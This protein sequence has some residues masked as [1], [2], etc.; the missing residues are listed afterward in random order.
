MTEI[1][2]PKR[3][4]R[5]DGLVSSVLG[6]SLSSTPGGIAISCS[7]SLITVGSLIR[8]GLVDVIIEDCHEMNTG[9]GMFR[10]SSEGVSSCDNLTMVAASLYKSLSLLLASVS[11][12]S[13]LSTTAAVMSMISSICLFMD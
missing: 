10:D 7:S 11:P 1:P 13:C 4:V 5:K 12:P 9:E 6:V 3:D 8:V 2:D